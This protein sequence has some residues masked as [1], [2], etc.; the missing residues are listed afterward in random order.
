[1][2]LSQLVLLELICAGFLV[3]YFY[4]AHSRIFH[5]DYSDYVDK[6]P[7]EHVKNFGKNDPG[8]VYW[9]DPVLGW[10][11]GPHLN[12]LNSSGCQGKPWSYSTDELGSRS[13]P[14]SDETALISLYGGSYTFGAEV[15]DHQTWQH[16]LSVLTGTRVHNFGVGAYGPDQALLKLERNLAKGI[17]T[18]IV[19]LGLY[20][21]GISR[22]V[23]TY[24]PFLSRD[25]GLRLGFKPRLTDKNGH[26]EWLGSPLTSLADRKTIQGGFEAA[27][28]DDYWYASNERK[29]R[30][31][32]P[33]SLTMASMAYHLVFE[34]ERKKSLWNTDHVAARNV[35]EIVRRFVEF[36]K[37]EDFVPVLVILPELGELEGYADGKPPY[38]QEFLEVVRETYD[39]SELILV[40]VYQE[41]F[42]PH[43]FSRPGCH[44]SEYGHRIIANSVHGKIEHLIDSSKP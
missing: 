37:Q 39:P 21:A 38:Y 40:D 15:D 33:Y 18:P 36:G 2:L 7:E 42:D 4:P 35:S 12:G 28:K 8:S 13:G 30:M 44:P 31:G 14:S 6:I 43:E 32:F 1:M 23:N 41:E 29:P 22:T 5:Y 20:S 27:K 16:F 19:A 26:Y 17:R 11:T 34:Y 9:F 24:R 10:N 25:A 3:F